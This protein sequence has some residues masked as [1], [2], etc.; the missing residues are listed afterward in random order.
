M[1][2]VDDTRRSA[3][4]ATTIGALG[5]VFGDIG[6]SPPYT[7]QTVFKG[8]LLTVDVLF[9]AANATK[10]THGAWLPLLSCR[11]RRVILDV[12]QVLALV[13]INPLV[14][15]EPLEDRDQRL[16]RRLEVRLTSRVSS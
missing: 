14:S 8:F 16:G 2:P 9:L 10:I 11:R 5:V 3:K 13:L 1:P 4:R 6:T 12:A 7:I 15:H